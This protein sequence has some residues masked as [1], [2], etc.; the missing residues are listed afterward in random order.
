MAERKEPHGQL[1]SV[2]LLKLL[3]LDSKASARPFWVLEYPRYPQ[4]E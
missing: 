2:G 1:V 4:Q 3:R